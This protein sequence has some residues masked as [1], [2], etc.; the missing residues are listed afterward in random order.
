[1]IKNATIALLLFV[2]FGFS[3]SKAIEFKHE[4]KELISYRFLSNGGM[5]LQFGKL[6]SMAYSP[7]KDKELVMVSSN[8]ETELLDMPDI[9]L[10]LR[11]IISP[12]DKL[13]GFYK[14]AG[15]TF[16]HDDIY[17]FPKNYKIIDGKKIPGPLK[18]TLKTLYSDDYIVSIGKEKKWSD[19]SFIKGEEYQ[20]LLFYR[21]NI[22]TFETK[23]ININFPTDS[24]PNNKMFYQVVY[25]DNNKIYFVLNEL[26]EEHTKNNCVL[27]SYDYDGKLIDNVPFSI[28]IS[29][30]YLYHFNYNSQTEVFM[31]KGNDMRNVPT[32]GS[33]V[34][35]V[36]SPD[37]QSF[38]N[39]GTYGDKKKSSGFFVHKYDFKGNLLWKINK[40][41]TNDK[42]PESRVFDLDLQFIANKNLAFMASIDGKL[43]FYKINEADG[44]I[45]D[46]KR[47]PYDFQKTEFNWK[48]KKI[49]TGLKERMYLKDFNDKIA[50]NQATIFAILYNPG[51]AAYLKNKKGSKFVTRLYPDGIYILE[52]NR[53]DSKYNFLKFN[54]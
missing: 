44:T 4:D 47:G 29:G 14:Q 23:L 54:W 28:D 35:C 11:A 37:G 32:D 34:K 45:I 38:Y 46:E 16:S 26:N 40:N 24:F 15:S 12:T 52:E 39:Y 3:Q 8:L 36:I 21:H 2:N 41:S 49:G 1:M 51:V 9:K 22:K 19:K 31:L 25:N 5:Y 42:D 6:Y 43:A 30:K 50:M 10:G 48:I 18:D 13:L 33:S 20:N 17:L 27:V 53:D 7:P